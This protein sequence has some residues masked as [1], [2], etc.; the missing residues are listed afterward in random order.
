[1]NLSKRTIVFTFAC[2]MLC[3]AVAFGQATSGTISGT[4]LDPQGNALSGATLKIK[5]LGT[6]ATREATTNSSGYYRVTG[7]MPGRYEV[8]ASAQ[9][10][11]GETRG[12]LALTVTEEKVVNFSLKVGMAKENVTVEVQSVSVETTG[13]T[14]SGLV[15]EKKIRDLPL[16]GR[17]ITQ[18]IFLQPGV[19]ESRGSAQTSNTGRGP[20]FSVAGARPSQNLFQIDGTTIND[21][22]NNTPGSAQGL[23]LG[24]ETIREFRVLTNT[25][26]AEYGRVSGGVFVAVTKSGS[27]DLHGTVF[28]FL[29]NGAVDARNFFDQQ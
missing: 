19:V 16:D 25:F 7:L 11:A 15:D 8:E 23:L 2:L 3:G 12:E 24:V 20:R 9:G 4:L 5:N 17:D 29:R 22:L 13:S 21:A 27:N 28:E 26:S 10:F 14:I 1:M 6:G 18:L